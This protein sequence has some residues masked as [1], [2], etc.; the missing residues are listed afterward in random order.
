MKQT[1]LALIVL[2]ALAWLTWRARGAASASHQGAAN[3]HSIAVAGTPRSY[4]LHI[5]PQLPA[6]QPAPLVL[7][8]HGGGGSG[9]QM[10]RLSKFDDLADKDGFLVAYPDGIDH[11][12]ND[13]RKNTAGP[14]DDVQFVDQLIDDV[15]KQHPVDPKRIFAT[16]ISNGGIFCH[17][18]AARLSRRIAAIAPAAGGIARDY[19]AQFA[20]AD[21][22]SVFII[23]GDADPLVPFAGGE[24][25]VG[26]KGAVIPTTQGAEDWARVDAC[27]PAD[28]PIALPDTDPDD[29]CTVEF[30]RWPGGRAGTEV[31]LYVIH[32]GGHTWPGGPQYL[33]RIVIGNVCRDFDATDEIWRF[34]QLHA[35]K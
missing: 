14:N 7:V 23:N 22:V 31:W 2:L 6:T 30:T 34:F 4:H 27:Q 11:H 21:P 18:L 33:P 10:E 25:P 8:F 35:R 3:N 1:V 29:G 19:Q 20:P 24:V 28:K 5:P 17:Y 32:G 13:G 15:G 26:R 12:W 9:R 16:G